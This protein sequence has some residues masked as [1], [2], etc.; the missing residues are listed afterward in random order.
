MT[1]SV[2][3]THAFRF[4]LSLWLVCVCLFCLMAYGGIR[5]PDGEVVFRIG[6]ALA[7]HGSF[8]V[9]KDLEA[10]PEFGLPK[11]IDG[12]R[13]AIFG[14]AQSVLLVPL[15]QAA[16]VINQSRWYEHRRVPV[17]FAADEF[18]FR[19]YILKQRP[20]DIGKHAL[21][22]LVS[23][24]NPLVTSV[25]VVLQFLIIRRLT[26]YL[27]AAFIAAL[28]LGLATPLWHY[29]GTMFTEPLALL[30][31]LVSFYLLLP[32]IVHPDA[33]AARRGP[34]VFFAGLFLGLAFT[35]HITAVLSVPF[36]LLFAIYPCA[37]TGKALLGNKR[38]C[39]MIIVNFMAGVGIMV[40]M[41]SGYNYMRFGSFLEEGRRASDLIFYGVFTTP[42]E[43][44][45]GLLASPGKGIFW[46]CPILIAAIWWWPSL[47]KRNRYL[48]S[49][50]IA[51]ALFRMVF[52][53]CRSD[54]H[55][56][57]CLGP[58]FALPVLPFLLIPIGCRLADFFESDSKMTGWLPVT[59]ALF[60]FV[61]IVQQ[62]Y[63]CLGEPI[64]FYYMIKMVYLQ[65]GISIIENNQIYFQWSASPLLHLFDGRRGPFLL[66]PLP[67]GQWEILAACSLGMALLL[68]FLVFYLIH[69][70]RK[71]YK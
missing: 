42:W 65:H 6:E 47:H 26:G 3:K 39:A 10:W 2:H 35:T 53:A 43:G 4:L 61:C 50:I 22:F 68:G 57:F 25:V 11:G 24:F 69:V 15:I 51:M 20:V 33:A 34:R 59:L 41:Y 63:F 48:S 67:M 62:I 36:F 55:G 5:T 19:S 54:W 18:S 52:I 29:S 58:R 60:F 28:L 56:G 46:F 66:Q 27:M 70:N 16:T 13:Y 71:L 32:G 8:A 7:R 38:I 44:V 30:F 45:P 40:L 12:R 23:F 49:V 21:R 1:T 31:S 17:S 37:R 14:P 9:D 64:S